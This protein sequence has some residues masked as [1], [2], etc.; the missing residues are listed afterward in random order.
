MRRTRRKRANIDKHHRDFLFRSAES[1]IARQYFLGC[2]PSN[3]SAKC[4]SQLFFFAQ[5]RHHQVELTDQRAEFVGPS[6][7]DLHVEPALRHRLGCL[8]QFIDRFCNRTANQER[9]KQC[10]CCADHTDKDAEQLRIGSGRR[11]RKKQQQERSDRTNAGRRER[12][13]YVQ[14]ATAARYAIGFQ[15]I[16]VSM[17]RCF[18][19]AAISSGS[20]T[21]MLYQMLNALPSRWGITGASAVTSSGCRFNAASMAENNREEPS[22]RAN[23]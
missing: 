7:R 19:P 9:G 2:L 14:M 15:T 1:R 12:M 21:V 11:W 18:N 4:L 16:T 17:K 13:R 20:T 3:V 5:S 6:Q 8:A 23:F 22:A 10:E